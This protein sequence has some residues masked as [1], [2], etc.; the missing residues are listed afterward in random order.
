V[1]TELSWTHYRELLRVEGA[2]ARAW[3]MNEA[4]TQNWSVLPET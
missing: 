4:A 1:R 2:E 3:Y